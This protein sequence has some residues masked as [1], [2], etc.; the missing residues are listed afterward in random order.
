MQDTT[1]PLSGEIKELRSNQVEIK[2][3]INEMQSKMESSTARINEAEERNT[4]LGDKMMENRVP[5]EKRDKQVLDQQGRV[6]E[7][8]DATKQNSI[9]NTGIPEEP[10]RERGKRYI[11]ENYSREPP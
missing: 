10:E 11:G 9:R 8:S 1:E 7:I 4:D 3:A 2:K 5:E 6:R